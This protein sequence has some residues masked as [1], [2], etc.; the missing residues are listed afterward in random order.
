MEV[1]AVILVSLIFSATSNF[2]VK[3]FRMREQISMSVQDA[4][5]DALSSESNVRLSRLLHRDRAL[6]R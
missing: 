6:Q 5:F 3:R 4:A 1:L 2:V